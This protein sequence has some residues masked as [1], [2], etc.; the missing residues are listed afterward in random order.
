MTIYRRDHLQPFLRELTEH[1]EALKRAVEGH[2]PN[3]SE[4][5]R[6]HANPEQ[7]EREFRDVDV[8]QVLLRLQYFQVAVKNLSKIKSKATKPVY[9]K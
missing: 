6:Y 3:P 1:Y 9:R 2:P 4:A 5:E 7:F 8:D